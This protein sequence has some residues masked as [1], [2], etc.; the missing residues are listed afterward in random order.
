MEHVVDGRRFG[1]SY[2]ELREN[3]GRI[4][5]LTD[6]EFLLRLPEAAHLACIIGWFKEL[7][8]EATIGELGIVREIVHL[9]HSGTTTRL[10]VIRENFRELLRLA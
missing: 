10:E 1:V 7:G 4:C 6:Q 9:M 2:R 3:Y 5:A 8:A